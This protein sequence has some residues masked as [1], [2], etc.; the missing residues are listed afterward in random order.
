MRTILLIAKDD[1]FYGPNRFDEWYITNININLWE[2]KI[3]FMF[4]YPQTLKILVRRV[5]WKFK[6]VSRLVC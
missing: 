5:S 3:V 6:I 2:N 1:L 4:I